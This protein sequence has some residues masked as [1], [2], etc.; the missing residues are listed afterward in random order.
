MSSINYK[1]FQWETEQRQNEVSRT[2]LSAF[3]TN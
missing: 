1:V 2:F 3:T